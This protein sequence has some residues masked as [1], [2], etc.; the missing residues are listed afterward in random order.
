MKEITKGKDASHF[1]PEGLCQRAEAVTFLYRAAGEPEVTTTE[2]PFDDVSESDY[3]Y[4]AVLWAVE[5]GVTKGVDDHT[6]APYNTCTRAQIVTFLCRANSGE[7]PEGTV[8]PF[9][10]VPAN[11]WYIVTFLFRAQ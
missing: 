4:N 6:F 5:T 2:N 9:D 7:V 3:F 10:D 8:N 11:E 1:D